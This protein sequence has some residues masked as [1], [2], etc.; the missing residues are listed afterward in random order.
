MQTYQSEYPM[1]PHYH[2]NL[3]HHAHATTGVE[4]Q[5]AAPTGGEPPWAWVTGSTCQ[6]ASSTGRAALG[7][8]STGKLDRQSSSGQ[9]HLHAHLF[10]H[11][12]ALA[13]QGPA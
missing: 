5:Q 3:D 9:M 1:N 11:A 6:W 8:S 4:P 7:E 12:L 2:L 10:Q 13:E